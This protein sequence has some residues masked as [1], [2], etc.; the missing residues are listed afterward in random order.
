H[1]AEGI[2]RRT[3]LASIFAVLVPT[4]V[5]STADA[6]LIGS[7]T[8]A[9][10]CATAVGGNVTASQ[11]SVVCG[12]PPEVLSELLRKSTEPLEQLV[13]AHKE[14]ISLLKQNLALNEGQIRAA[15][16]AA[17]EAQV[18]PERLAAKLVEIAE[19]YASL[20]TA[21]APQPN[22]TAAITNLKR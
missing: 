19:R 15:L 11:I 14:T 4:I 20:R 1:R 8:E 7:R 5:A 17:G 3:A 22:D 18:E 9:S 16:Q 6:Q 12:I 21:A 2:M 13:G 10:S